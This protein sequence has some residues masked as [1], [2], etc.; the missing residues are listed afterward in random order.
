VRRRSEELDLSKYDTDKIPNNYLKIYDRIFEPLIDQ[1]IKLL[2]LGVRTG[3]SLRLW[4]D[5]F[6]QSTVAGLDLD[7][8]RGERREK[9]LHIFK[10]PQEDISLLS[11][12]AAEV[13]PEGFDIVIDD[14][15]HI[16]APTRASFWHLFDQHLKPGGL[17]AIEDWGTGYWERWPD[18]K[19]LRP[20]Q[21]H[22]AGMVGFIKELIDE[23]GAHDATRGWYD[24]PWERD[25][26]FESM[27]LVSSIAI[28]TK[29]R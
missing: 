3:G 5:Y 10:G 7:P 26:R 11:K 25:S 24:E 18:G 1:R 4:R 2:E 12:I 13:A 27:F 23:Q 15:S 17:F 21:P 22:H 9:R 29:R 16:A 19:A 14:A 6:P 28:V 8:P 20:E